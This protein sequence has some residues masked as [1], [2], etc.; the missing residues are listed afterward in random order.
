M[1]GISIVGKISVGVLRTLSTPPM[2][3]SIAITT[4]VYG[5]RSAIRI[6]HIEGAQF[7]PPDAAVQ[8]RNS[9]LLRRL[10][11]QGVPDGFHPREKCQE[12]LA[13][14]FAHLRVAVPPP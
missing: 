12:V 4:N 3:I 5:L 2:A 1:T 8:R 9:S 10:P 13:E 6:N 11:V 14:D 7:A